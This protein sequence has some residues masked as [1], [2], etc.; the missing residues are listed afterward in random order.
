M[1]KIIISLFILFLSSS[2]V[3]ADNYSGT[4]YNWS[5]G[6]MSSVD[7]TFNGSEMEVYNYN[8]GNI[9][10]HDIDSNNGGG[11]FETYNWETGEFNSI[12]LD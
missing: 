6:E 10:Y 7:V 1:K 8:T 11:S 5:T 12:D 3:F 4:S 9:E 2:L